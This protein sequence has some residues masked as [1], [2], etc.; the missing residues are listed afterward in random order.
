MQ[1]QGPLSVFNALT[2]RFL[3]SVVMLAVAT[4]VA[5]GQVDINCDGMKVGEVSFQ[6]ATASD[7]SPGVVGS[8][9]ATINDANG[10]P[11]IDAAAAKCDEDH[12]NWYQTAEGTHP[13]IPGGGPQ[14]DPLPGGNN[15]PGDWADKLPWYWDEGA[16]PPAGTPGFSDGY[17]VD[18]NTFD[19]NKDGVKDT[20]GY[21]DF[22]A[23]PAGTNVTF[24]TWLVSLNADGSLHSFHDGGIQWNYSN[25]AVSGE[26]TSI[27]LSLEGGPTAAQYLNITN[28]V[29]TDFTSSVPATVWDTVINNSNQPVTWGPGIWTRDGREIGRT[30]PGGIP[31]PGLNPPETNSDHQEL[32]ETPNDFHFD[33]QIGSVYVQ[34]D[35]A[36]DTNDMPELSFDFPLFTVPEIPGL[37]IEFDFVSGL[38][39]VLNLEA[40]TLPP[41]FLGPLEDL[42][43]P[44]LVIPGAELIGTRIGQ[45]HLPPLPLPPLEGDYNGDGRVGLD[46]L[47][48]VLTAWGTTNYGTGWTEQLPFQPGFDN[49]VEVPVGLDQLNLVL[50]NWGA[51]TLS[52]V[53]VPE[54]SGVQLFVCFVATALFVRRRSC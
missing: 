28:P 49:F 6:T 33:A 22:P 36:W 10:K 37:G 12:F 21:Q 51:E 27:D 44:G 13:L 34:V 7:G 38:G 15:P 53:P 45:D 31:Q 5:P 23:G 30:F 32:P 4:S 8:F 42:F 2:V 39:T 54:P 26:S 18:D 24:H 3:T 25:S 48:L 29:T 40:P 14:P 43:D 35:A 47:N 19:S 9:V 41:L 20:L 52:P 17:H 1:Y 16:D 46:D 50:S 11:S